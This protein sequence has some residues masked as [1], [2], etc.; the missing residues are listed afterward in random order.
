M[1]RAAARAALAAFVALAALAA[2]VVPLEEGQA[3]ARAAATERA[4]AARKRAVALARGGE[5][6]AAARE[7]VAVAA[8]DDS[9]APLAL[10]APVAR[11]RLLAARGEIEYLMGRAAAAQAYLAAA[12]READAA[13]IAG[14]GDGASASTLGNLATAA[15]WAGDLG[16]AAAAAERAAVLQPGEARHAHA[17][18]ATRRE[19]G[20]SVGAL[21]ALLDAP[22]GLRTSPHARE[23]AQLLEDMGLRSRAA[24]EALAATAGVD[25]WEPPYEAACASGRILGR[26]RRV[27]DALDESMAMNGRSFS[28]GDGIVMCAGGAYLPHLYAALVWLREGLKV[29]L[30]VQ[31]FYA[32][33]IPSVA[34]AAIEARFEDVTLVDIERMRFG[35]ADSGKGVD[36]AAAVL[37]ALGLPLDGG[38]I[39]ARLQGWQLKVFSVWASRFDRVLYLDVDSHP[40]YDVSADIFGANG[41]LSKNPL[42]IWPDYFDVGATCASPALYD[43]LRVPEQAKKAS[44]P[45]AETGQL[46]VDKRNQL[47]ARAVALW[48][49]LNVDAHEDG[50][51]Y[52]HSYGDKDLLRLACAYDGPHTLR[53]YEAG[54]VRMP[55]ETVGFVA[56]DEGELCGTALV[57]RHPQT[58]APMYLHRTNSK[59]ALAAP[60][61][62]ARSTL[63]GP[64]EGMPRRSRR[65]VLSDARGSERAA[66]G[67]M[68]DDGLCHRTR[69]RPAPS[70]ALPMRVL[71]LKGALVHAHAEWESG[72]LAAQCPSASDY[73]EVGVEALESS[74]KRLGARPSDVAVLMVETRALPSEGEPL[75]ETG[76]P[77]HVFGVA[78]MA[79]YCA[80]HGHALYVVGS[81]SA[82]GVHAND[83]GA[84]RGATLGVTWVRVAA[85]R[86]LLRTG[87]HA[88]VLYV[89]TDAYVTLPRMSLGAI[90]A[91]AGHFDWGP[92]GAGSAASASNGADGGEGHA[93]V[94]VAWD[95]LRPA[96][97]NTGVMFV[98][99][100]SHAR[101]LLSVWMDSA[102]GSSLAIDFPWEQGA[103]AHVLSRAAELGRR[104]VHLTRN[105]C[106]INGPFGALIRHYVGGYEEGATRAWYLQQAFG[107]TLDRERRTHCVVNERPPAGQTRVSVPL[108][109]LQASDEALWRAALRVINEPGAIRMSLPA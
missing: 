86:S 47:G 60:A 11:A 55:P 36:V 74:A 93:S 65:V 50:D 54:L 90:F 107:C 46:A 30:P 23:L 69:Q 84:A 87:A 92:V 82:P 4:L 57:Q 44:E 31:V 18:G 73:D 41:L 29:S 17:L 91:A 38:A 71:A 42:A 45:C 13:G 5:L 51:A 21:Q 70:T 9:E 8:E 63:G 66:G 59:G 89:D 75:P 10:A 3:A 24:G 106:P 49:A 80:T 39:A 40:L 83:Y 62:W 68:V 79:A 96:E 43:M 14:D 105:G 56:Y 109:R 94:S 77:Y 101:D 34:A 81:A 33:D 97:V 85:L 22:R 52:S 100:N 61:A 19:S 95:W 1:A 53:A 98:S 64:D 58:S 72:V 104:A 20:D 103:F 2:L 6:S 7:L 26:A 32:R 67:S 78:A 27:R 16:S 108:E 48:L 35:G 102:V 25:G 15:H 12:V 76:A 37:D 99:N 28:T 88:H